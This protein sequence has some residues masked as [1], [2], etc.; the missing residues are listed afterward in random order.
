MTAC[1][2]ADVQE[3]KPVDSIP[4]HGCTVGQQ[5]DKETP[6]MVINQTAQKSYYLQVRAIAT[7][8]A[9]PT[10]LKSMTKE[11]E[12]ERSTTAANQ[13]NKQ[14]E[15]PSQFEQWMVAI[16]DML[17]QLPVKPTV[18]T[19]AQITPAAKSN[20]SSVNRLRQGAA[21][22]SQKLNKLK[23]DG[24][25][26]KKQA[27]A[28]TATPSPTFGVPLSEVTNLRGGLPRVVYDS[29][30]YLEFHST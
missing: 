24:S 19:T 18:D 3:I 23:G 26:R 7:H 5:Y 12:R 14:A 28:R 13:S 11:R 9:A 29:L 1:V 10:T 6:I 17:Q 2:R 16:G 22:M 21:D 4:L 27:A 8:S 25:R 20:R 15:T 30:Q